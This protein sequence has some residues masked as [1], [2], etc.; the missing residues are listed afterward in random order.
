MECPLL[1]L[2]ENLECR[3]ML[4]QKFDTETGPLW[5]VQIITI[6]ELE[7]ANL[8]FGPEVEAIIED[9]SSL[10]TRWRYFLRYLQ[11]RLNQDIDSFEEMSSEEEG[12]SVVI[13]TFHPAITD[14]TGAFYLAK[15]FMSIMDMLLES[16]GPLNLGEPENIPSSIESLLP[17]PDSSF[18][19][20][21]LFP[22][23]KAVGS[24]FI[25]LRKSACE[26]LLVN[27]D[28]LNG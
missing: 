28:N 2:D 20:G 13:M 4:H 1:P 6:N 8:N 9:D 14:T 17:S 24:H 19:L 21:D 22:M 11:G 25:S 23:V 3:D 7:K 27:P 15:Q 16:D 18:H 26:A 5:R 12:R 10:E